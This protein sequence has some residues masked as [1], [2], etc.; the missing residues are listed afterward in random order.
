VAWAER[1]WDDAI[2]ALDESGRSVIASQLRYHPRTLLTAQAHRLAGR[3]EAA[4]AA[5]D[6]ARGLLEAELATTP[7]DA[8]MHVA[9]GTALAGLGRGPDAVREAERALELMPLSRDAL[10]AQQI[11]LQAAAVFADAGQPDRAV[12]L[13]AALFEQPVYGYARRQLG[14]DPTW[15]RLRS[16][17]DFRRLQQQ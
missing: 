2:R 17:Q 13:L 11:H 10:I 8:R 4:R 15:E 14:V 9:L 7:D 12:Q 1:R 6:T 16:R 3:A 5:Y